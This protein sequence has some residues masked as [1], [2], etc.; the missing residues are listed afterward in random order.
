MD[1]Q[2]TDARN[3]ADY[4]IA[5]KQCDI[6]ELEQLLCNGRLVVAISNLV[7]AL[8]RER[9]QSN[10][11]VASGGTCCA[12]SL[13]HSAAGT[14][15]AE[16]GFRQSLAEIDTTPGAMVGG[17]RLL[18]RIAHALHGIA[19]VPSLRRK[20]KALRLQPEQIIDG[21]SEVVQGLL[22]VVFEAAD[23]AGDPDISRL[24]VALFHLVQG[25]E[26]VGQERATGAA[27]FARGG[28][29]ATLA[30]RLQRLID[31]QERCFQVFVDFA[32]PP[33]LELWRE[34]GPGQCTAELERLRRIALTGQAVSDPELGMVWFDAVTLR[35]DAMRQV[36]D[37]L[38]QSLAALCERR[39]EE[40]RADLASHRDLIAALDRDSAGQGAFAVFYESDPGTASSGTRLAAETQ[41]ANPRLGRSLVELVQSQSRRLQAMNEEL[42]RARA[43]LSERKMVEKAKGLIMKHRGLEEE[44]AYRFLQEVAMAQSRRLA[45]VARDAIALSDIFVGPADTTPPDRR[46]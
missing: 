41:G 39:I 22:S 8:Q 37:R 19:A 14:D 4:L 16:R 17:S 12:E 21:Y 40:A 43:A 18:T 33:T 13:V 25:K 35:I 9:G 1:P 6:H 42:Q 36:E 23:T 28:F 34:T 7:H 45:D 46:R 11:F 27:G 15:Q 5:S 2:D 20:V 32:D 3:A 38:Q 31:S 44:A 30:S 26:L 24:L 29:D 10:L